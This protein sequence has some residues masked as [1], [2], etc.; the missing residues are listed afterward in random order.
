MP[1]IET[2]R[3]LKALGTRSMWVKSLYAWTTSLGFDLLKF[4]D[5]IRGLPLVLRDYILLKSL[6]RSTKQLWPLSLTLPSLEDKYAA[7]GVAEGHYFHQDLLVARR[8]YERNP[9]K[10]IDVGSRVDG[11]VSHV[12]T[13]RHI[14]VLDI[15]PLTSQAANITFTQ[16][17]LMN[18]TK[19]FTNYCDSLSC[20]HTLE[21]F[22]LGRYGDPLNING[23]IQGF[24]NLSAMLQQNGILYLSVPIG[25]QRID[26]NA[27]RVFNISTI[28]NLAKQKFDLIQFSFVDDL[29]ALHEN[30]DLNDSVI[31]RNYGCVYGCGI[32]EF[33]KIR[34]CSA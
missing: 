5:A 26:F 20:L 16:A 3:K 2:R 25:R 12:A 23:Y 10:H 28:L 32:F 34:N 9:K 7:S 8:V 18:S 33:K 13:F 11:F 4:V 17:D 24:E 21:H 19:N 1:S 6:N 30:V 14:E 22:G 27:H 29:G 15:R 31:E